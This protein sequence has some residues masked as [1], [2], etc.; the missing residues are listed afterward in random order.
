M[1][2]SKRLNDYLR[3]VRNIPFKWGEH[4]CLTFSNGAFK[5]YHGFGY[6]DDWIGKYLVGGKPLS[7]ADMR[8]TF[9]ARTFEEAMGRK[10]RSVEGVPPRGAVVATKKAE[11][12][13]I[14]YA[15]GIC[16]GARAAFLSEAGVVYFPLDDV[17]MAWVLE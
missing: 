17:D 8:E 6:A 5:A 13:L 9:G 4:D 11:R 3:R 12:W 2:P 14:G 7:K 15:L 16:V 1:G 10:L